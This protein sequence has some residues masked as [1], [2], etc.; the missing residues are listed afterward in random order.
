MK[1]PLRVISSEFETRYYI[2]DADDVM[3]FII[4][5]ARRDRALWFA[6]NAVRALNEEHRAAELAQRLNEGLP[7]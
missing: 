5:A 3:L 7:P 6:Q 2:A 4:D 1:Y